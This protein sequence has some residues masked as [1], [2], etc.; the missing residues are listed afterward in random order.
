MNS[1]LRIFLFCPV[2]ENQ[3]PLNELIIFQ[4]NFFN[5]NLCIS[6][7][8]YKKN[9]VFSYLFFFFLNFLFFLPFQNLKNQESAFS[10]FFFLNFSTLSFFFFFFFLFFIRWIILENRLKNSRL[11]YEEGS[12]YDGQI[13]EKPFF[14]IKNDRLLTTQKIQPIVQRISKTSLFLFYIIF[15]FSIPLNFQS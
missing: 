11:F 9:L 6:I 8:K 14:L 10:F 5:K 13:W 2:P 7:E 3:K 4:E 15:L 1:L 12:W